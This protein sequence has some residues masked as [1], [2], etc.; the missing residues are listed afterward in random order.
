[1]RHDNLGSMS[2][3]TGHVGLPTGASLEDKRTEGAGLPRGYLDVVPLDYF[4]D[5]YR[6]NRK[7]QLAE[8]RG[9][10]EDGTG[11]GLTVVDQ[12][13]FLGGPTT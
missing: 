1:M 7:N 6:R 3:A 13:K 10:L 11:G 8:R 2:S 9:R 12:E 5:L 4:E